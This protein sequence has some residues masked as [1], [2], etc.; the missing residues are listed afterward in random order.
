MAYSRTSS[1]H[2]K[3]IFPYV[4][5]FRILT[6]SRHDGF[7]DLNDGKPFLAP[8]GDS[9]GNILDVWTGPGVWA[10]YAT[11]NAHQRC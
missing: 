6:C 3:L 10:K 7:K 4:G 1:R 5:T 9:A 11:P 8:L 2:C